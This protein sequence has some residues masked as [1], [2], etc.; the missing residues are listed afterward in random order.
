MNPRKI[1]PLDPSVYEVLRAGGEYAMLVEQ[2]GWRRLLDELSK[3]ADIALG[4]LRD[5]GSS[6]ETTRL[7]LVDEWARLERYLKELY[8]KVYGAIRERERLLIELKENT[9]LDESQVLAEWTM[10]E[11]KHGR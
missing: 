10:E 4:K 8:V 9:G 1:E 6:D 5:C 7:R 11:M 2:A 3:D